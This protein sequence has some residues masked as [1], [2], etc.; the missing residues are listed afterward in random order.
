MS[1]YRQPAPRERVTWRMRLRAW[2]DAQWLPVPTPPSPL[3]W[4]RALR[5][6]WNLPGPL[7]QA[8]TAEARIRQLTEAIKLKRKEVDALRENIE[9]LNAVMR[10]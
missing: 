5:D 7:E 6:L 1:P 2:W 10:R 9:A 8:E 4:Y 3:A